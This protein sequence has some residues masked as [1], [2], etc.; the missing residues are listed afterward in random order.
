MNV[1]TEG[2]IFMRQGEKSTFYG[3]FKLNGKQY[4]FTVYPNM[5]DDMKVDHF[6]GNIKENTQTNSEEKN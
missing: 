3:Y 2:R 1:E 5:G 6:G 4:R